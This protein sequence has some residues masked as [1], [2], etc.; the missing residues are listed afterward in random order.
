MI[1]SETIIRIDYL[2]PK[3]LERRL[4]PWLNMVPTPRFTR[5]D[6]FFSSTKNVHWQVFLWPS[7]RSY[8]GVAS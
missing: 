6:A 5:A 2:A 7:Q 3:M 1:V 8:G 4:D